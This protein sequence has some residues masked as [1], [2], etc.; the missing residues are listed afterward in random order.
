MPE[1]TLKTEEVANSKIRRHFDVTTQKWYFSVVDVIGALTDSSDARNYWKVLKNRLKKAHPELVTLF[2]QSNRL[3]MRAKDGKFYL[4]DVADTETT[5]RIIESIPKASGTP[6]LASDR[7]QAFKVLIADIQEIQPPVSPLSGGTELNSFSP[8]K[9]R[10]R[11]VELEKEITEPESEAQLLVDAYETETSIF[12]KAMIAGVSLADLNIS[13]TSNKI[14]I[15]G[16]REEPKNIFPEL[17]QEPFLRNYLHE[18]L[19]W[20]TF[21]R[22]ISLPSPVRS[23]SLKKTEY[24]GRITIELQKLI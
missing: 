13:V 12:I 6:S 23:D 2:N 21:S 11:G 5:I 15:S 1:I 10:L 16:K 9:G 18:E 14:I 3:K 8:D 7:V 24:R 19:L 20:V 4:T 22:A 17:S